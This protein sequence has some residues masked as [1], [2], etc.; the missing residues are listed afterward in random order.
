MYRLVAGSLSPLFV[1]HGFL[2]PVLRL[3]L[4]GGKTRHRFPVHGG[5]W[6]R[7]VVRSAGSGRRTNPVLL[8]APQWHFPSSRSSAQT[9]LTSLELTH[10]QLE[11][12]S[13]TSSKEVNIEARS[14]ARRRTSTSSRSCLS[15][16]S[17]RRKSAVPSCR[18][19]EQ[20]ITPPLND[21]QTHTDTPDV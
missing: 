9:P 15:T 14:G 4:R 19:G 5:G 13:G 7:S 21:S 8:N 12:I 3:L 17:R 1:L 2:P 16:S 10:S 6:A 20:G 11:G 18:Q